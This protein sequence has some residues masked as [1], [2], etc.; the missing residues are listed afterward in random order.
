MKRVSDIDPVVLERV[1][2]GT[3]I[4]AQV[5]ALDENRKFS[6]RHQRALCRYFIDAGVG[7]IAV[8]VHSTQFAIR[9]PEIG[10][11]ETVLR[12]TGKFIDEYCAEKAKKSSRS[13]VSAAKRS[14]HCGRRNLKAPAIMTLFCFRLP[15]SKIL[16][17]MK[18]SP[19]AAKWLK[20]CL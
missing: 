20:S 13:A 14:R 17:L 6:P 18:C 3:V 11:F 5:L 8:G 4:P 1:R 19:I 12:E 2:K 15:R 9:N 16:L 10:L 7:G